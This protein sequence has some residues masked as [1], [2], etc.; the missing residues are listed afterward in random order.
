MRTIHE[1]LDKAR[2]VQKVPSDYKLGLTL[3][4]G[5]NALS[6]YRTG[7]SLPDEKTCEILARA[8]G[9]DP[10]LLTV[11]MQAQ[12]AKTPEARKVWFNI[13]QRLQMGFGNVSLLAAIA[14]VL[15]ATASP[16]VRAAS[17][18]TFGASGS[19]YIMLSFKNGE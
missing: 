19:L 11:E 3:G 5:G 16:A 18:D 2:A 4:I 13:A 17:M 1:V 9:E 8:M 6:N 7:R 14:I 12:R 10:A 15:I